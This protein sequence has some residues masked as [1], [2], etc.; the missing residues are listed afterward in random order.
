MVFSL[1]ARAR[2]SRERP[3]TQGRKKFDDV[4]KIPVLSWDYSFLGARNRINEAEAEQRGD[5]PVLVMH[6]GVT[7]VDFCSFDPSERG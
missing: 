3:G 7:E 6:D 4:S 1:C 2:S 5:S